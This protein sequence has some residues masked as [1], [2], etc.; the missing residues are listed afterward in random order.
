MAQ[1]FE[2][3]NTRMAAMRVE[4]DRLKQLLDSQSSSRRELLFDSMIQ[5]LSYFD[6]LLTV[7]VR[8]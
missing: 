6:E 8:A 4:R 5:E 2:E 3:M 1:L 7:E